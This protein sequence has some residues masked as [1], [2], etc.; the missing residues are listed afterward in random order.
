VGYIHVVFLQELHEIIPVNP[1]MA[2]RKS[3]SG[4]AFFINPAQNR[5]RAYTAMLG[6]E[7]GGYVFWTPMLFFC[8]QESLLM[9]DLRGILV[10][11]ISGISS[12][13]CVII[14]LPNLSHSRITKQT[15]YVTN[16]SPLPAIILNVLV[17]MGNGQAAQKSC[18][19]M[20]KY[21]L[22]FILTADLKEII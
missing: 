3:E 15:S 14:T 13:F 7:T 6:D 17:Q 4:K 19:M 20:R 21:R 8:F 9:I 11:W 10:S 5:D 1:V 2:F 12:G 18:G 22:D 16:I